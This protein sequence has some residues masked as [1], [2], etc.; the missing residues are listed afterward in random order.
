[1]QW[2][3]ILPALIKCHPIF[4]GFYIVRINQNYYL[5]IMKKVCIV[6]AQGVGTKEFDVIS[7][8]QIFILGGWC[9]SQWM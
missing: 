6:Q 9:A 2:D 4:F 8:I 5:F 3:N 1:M 7:N